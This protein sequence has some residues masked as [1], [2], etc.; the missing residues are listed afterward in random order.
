[1]YLSLGQA[2]KG[3]V[4]PEGRGR[5]E[6]VG[7]RGIPA[8]GRDCPHPCGVGSAAIHRRARGIRLGVVYDGLRIK[9]A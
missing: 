7:G 1:M 8:V 5:G 6:T 2:P 9:E 3:R 4:R